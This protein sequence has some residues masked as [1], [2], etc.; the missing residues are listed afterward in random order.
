[1]EMNLLHQAIV[2]VTWA[3]QNGELPDPVSH[4]AT[5]REI[6]Q[7]VTEA[8]RTG[9]IPGI[10][11]DTGANLRDFLVDRFEPTKLRPYKLVAVRPKTPFG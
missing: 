9:G 5:D 7:W 1:M 10:Q 2:N 8:V 6:L 3:G 4:D 11:E